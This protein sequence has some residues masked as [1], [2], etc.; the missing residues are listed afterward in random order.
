MILVDLQ[1]EK[2]GAPHPFDM[3]GAPIRCDLDVH[4]RGGRPGFAQIPERVLAQ[5]QTNVIAS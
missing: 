3:A 2:F 4:E 5:D 1:S